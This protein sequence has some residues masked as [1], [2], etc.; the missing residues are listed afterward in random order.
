MQY[1]S[2]VG[3]TAFIGSS[4]LLMFVKHVVLVC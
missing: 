2:T 1:E 4:K 3:K